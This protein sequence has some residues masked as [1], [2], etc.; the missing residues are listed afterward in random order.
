VGGDP[1]TG[2]REPHAFRPVILAVDDD[3]GG[4]ERIERELRKRYEADYGV[5]CEGSAEAGLEKLRDLAAAGEEVAVVLASQLMSEMAGVEFLTRAH[6]VFPTAK[7]LILT[8]MGDRASQEGIPEALVLGRIDYYEPKPGP[9]P[10]ERFHEIVT[11]L[12]REWTKPYRY[13]LNAVVRV[14]GER[15]SRRSHEAR[16]ILER[17]GL[18]HAFY[19]VDTNEGQELLERVGR[20]ANRLPVW[21]LNDGQVL[22]DPSNEEFADAFVGRVRQ[23]RQ[24]FEVVVIGGGP[25]GLAAAVYGV[26]EGLSTLVVEGEAIGGQAGAR[27]L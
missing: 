25:A 9:P 10:N 8:D 27:A 23:G 26:S 18:P 16:D 17:Y 13:E 5:A 21:V 7:R 12:L 3:P 24:D 6:R 4:L 2:A 11:S 20:T 19:P 14:V 1:L 22:V 15:W